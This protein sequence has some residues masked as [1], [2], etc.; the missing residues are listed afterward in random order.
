MGESIN[1]SKRKHDLLA[2]TKEL[3]KGIGPRIRT[4]REKRE[5]NQ[6]EFYDFLFPESEYQTMGDDASPKTEGMKI[7][8]IREI[9]SGKVINISGTPFN[10]ETGLAIHLA[11]LLR[12][13]EKCGV[14][15]D[16]LIAGKD[17]RPEGASCPPEEK[18][19]SG[20]GKDVN[21][22]TEGSEEKTLQAEI[23]PP[24]IYFTCKR[25]PFNEME[26]GY[27]NKPYCDELNVSTLD[28]CKSLVALSFIADIE[29][30]NTPMPLNGRYTGG[31]SLTILPKEIMLPI[32]MAETGL[33]D[34]PF[35]WVVDGFPNEHTDSKCFHL[36]DTRGVHCID[37]L[38]SLCLDIKT[39]RAIGALPGLVY[40]NIGGKLY[41]MMEIGD[42]SHEPLNYAINFGSYYSDFLD[43][44]FIIGFQGLS[45]DVEPYS[46][47]LERIKLDRKIG[48]LDSK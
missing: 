44:D 47:Y 46:S 38:R 26:S 35:M 14:S 28:I 5:M 42:I 10:K 2:S 20:G 45:S 23:Q 25:R 40:K 13:S 29:I 3:A 30:S 7:K 18:A 24:S 27:F 11:L 12:I 21:Q 41:S 19:I 48:Q 17:F 8:D 6:R 16:Y 33:K 22:D 34:N 32:R 31:L 9:E 1:M 4:L 43:T 15:L 36:V 39:F 37:F